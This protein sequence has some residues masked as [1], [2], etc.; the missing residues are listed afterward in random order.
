MWKIWFQLPGQIFT[1]FEFQEMSGMSKKVEDGTKTCNDTI[2]KLREEVLEER[3][4]GLDEQRSASKSLA[5]ENT[6]LEKKL[7]KLQS[8]FENLGQEL[9]KLKNSSR[10]AV[11]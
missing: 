1:A 10:K 3:A 6:R 4:S 7:D 11:D 2:K 9:N 8:Q 5:L